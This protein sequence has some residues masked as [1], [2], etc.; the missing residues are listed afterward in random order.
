MEK[1]SKS[2]P[3]CPSDPPASL[4]DAA[5]VPIDDDLALGCECADPLLQIERWRYEAVHEQ[6]RFN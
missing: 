5:R 3:R 2:L 6:R 4:P 1:L